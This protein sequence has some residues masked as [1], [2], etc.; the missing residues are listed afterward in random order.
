MNNSYHDSTKHT[1]FS[2]RSSSHY[3]DWSKM[4]I[5]FK[6]YPDTFSF[7]KLS[8]KNIHDRFIY[9]IG[10]VT[11]KKVYPGVE[12]YLRTVPSAGALYP[13]E[14]YFQARGVDGFED[15]IYHF[16]PAQNGVRLLYRLKENEG[17]EYHFFDKRE[18]E[19][20]IFLF[21]A[22]YYR[23]SWKYSNRAF[24]YTLL[25]C[26]HVL[27]ALEAGSYLYNHAYFIIYNFDKK[28]LNEKF[29]FKNQEFFLSAARVGTPRNKKVKFF[30][31]DLEF[32]DPT[33]NFQINEMIEKS[34]INTLEL[35]GCKIEYRFNKFNF[36]KDRFYETII[37]RRSIREFLKE[38][39]KKEEFESIYNTLIQ[40]ITSD[41]DE[42]I[43]IYYFINRVKDMEK[44]VYKN[45]KIL[46]RGD[47]SSK[48]K[49]LCLEQA[50]GGDSAVTFF[51]TSN[52]NNYQPLCQK[53]GIIGHRC[54]L[55]SEY[56]QIGCS[57]IGAYYD[58]DVKDFLNSN[59]LILY[60]LAIGR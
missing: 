56:L 4:P 12:Y 46:K 31:L 60:A 24:R 37:N 18:I 16:S 48:A 21:S 57:G 3:L 29:G 28:V 9:L 14:I 39:I 47:F 7:K 38:P 22:V 26:G 20:F 40:P 53:A 55:A 32:V 36:N 54:Y 33:L 2:V 52:K 15:G 8:L 23:S 42:E 17:I 1:Y 43:N 45:H 27:G 13:I 50:L 59:D 30:D 49:F 58:D 34:Y 41:C 25:D 19:G 44:G 35:N 10:G 51:L 11:A 5:P 6:I